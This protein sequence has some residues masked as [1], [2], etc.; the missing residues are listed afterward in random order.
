MSAGWI[1]LKH[2]ETGGENRFPDSPGVADFYTARGWEVVDPPK[3]GPFVAEPSDLPPSGDEWVKL[4]HPEANATHDFPNNPGAIV[5]ALETG[6][7]L[8]KPPEPEPEPEPAEESTKKPAKK[9]AP[10]AVESKE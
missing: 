2:K 5:G 10:A 8:P 7:E 3:G 1:Y 9:A 4:Y 6:W